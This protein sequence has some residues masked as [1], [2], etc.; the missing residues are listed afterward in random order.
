MKH[1]MQVQRRKIEIDKWLEGCRIGRDPG[2][3]YVLNWIQNNGREF[4]QIWGQSLC[5]NCDSVENCG[6]ELRQKCT[7]YNNHKNKL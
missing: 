3:E 6:H 5:A 1:F 2:S 7:E 4:R